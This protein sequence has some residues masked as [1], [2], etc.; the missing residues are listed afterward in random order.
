MY[1]KLL[2]GILYCMPVVLSFSLS[3]E[4]ENNCS[5]LLILDFAVYCTPLPAATA[6]SFL[7]V[8]ITFIPKMHKTLTV[9]SLGI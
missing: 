7:L 8:K 1:W 9:C 3:Q 2:L 4:V 5:M 6:C